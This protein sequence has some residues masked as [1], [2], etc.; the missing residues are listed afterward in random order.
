MPFRGT[1]LAKPRGSLRGAGA[2]IGHPSQP[3]AGR[4]LAVQ[5][6]HARPMACTDDGGPGDQGIVSG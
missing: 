1:A 2:V 5:V 3:L 4:S 6:G